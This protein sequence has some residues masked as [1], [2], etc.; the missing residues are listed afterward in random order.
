MRPG[1][2]LARS[3][4]VANQPTVGPPKDRGVPIDWPSATTISKP[5]DPGVFN[6]PSIDGST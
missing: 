2:N 6:T 3:F 1:T 4:L 5:I